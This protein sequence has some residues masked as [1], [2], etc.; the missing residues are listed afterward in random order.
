M[1]AKRTLRVPK[2]HREIL[3]RDRETQFRDRETQFRG[4]FFSRMILPHRFL[5]FSKTDAPRLV[6]THPFP[7]SF[8]S[9]AAAAALRPIT[10]TFS[11]AKLIA[12]N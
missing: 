8:Y 4:H 3:F 1:Y 6:S 7:L 11:G 10:L 2:T 9:R 12:T 5:E